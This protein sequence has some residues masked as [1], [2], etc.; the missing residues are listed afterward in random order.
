MFNLPNGKATP[1]QIL[2]PVMVLAIV[3]FVSM[4]IQFFQFMRDR[5][6]LH[7]ARMQQEKAF[8]DASHLADQ[9]N[10]LAIGTKELADK[11]DKDAKG[12]IERMN[13]LGIDVKL[14]PGAQVPATAAR[15]PG[16]APM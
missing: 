3:V 6:E 7:Q 5:N 9:L 16:R 13:K 4:G 15:M 14:P 10:A 1:S 11:G 8:E 12:I 2:F